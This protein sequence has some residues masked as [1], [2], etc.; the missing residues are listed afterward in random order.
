MWDTDLKSSDSDRAVSFPLKNYFSI[1]DLQ[2]AFEETL[3]KLRKGLMLK[4]H[5][6]LYLLLD[7]LL[8]CFQKANLLPK[9]SQC[10]LG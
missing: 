1:Y 3:A 5:F 7:V 4:L 2:H 10:P 9:V 6:R 8:G